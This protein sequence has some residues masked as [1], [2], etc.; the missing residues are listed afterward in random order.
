MKT[1][2]T[3]TSREAY[4]A[5]QEEKKL[6]LVQTIAAYIL[7]QTRAGKPTCI[8]D[9]NHHF[10]VHPSLFQKSTVS[11]R[12]NELKQNGVTLK[13]R[14]YILQ[15]VEVKKSTST[16]VRAEHFCLILEG[17]I[18]EKLPEQLTIFEL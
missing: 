5:L 15:M 14:R 3:E 17:N 12:L 7:E 6:S 1:N 10:R 8:A 11:A 4:H 2:V 18:T 9:I 16:N 13:G